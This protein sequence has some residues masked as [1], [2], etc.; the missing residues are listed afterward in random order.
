[1]SGDGS[2]D[3]P[4]THGSPDVDR[5]RKWCRCARCGTVAVCR[6]RFDFYT[7]GGEGNENGPLRC[8]ACLFAPPVGIASA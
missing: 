3:A 5:R 2:R 1:M 4:F 8:E 7:P 6:P